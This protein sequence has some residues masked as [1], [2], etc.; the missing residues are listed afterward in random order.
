VSDIEKLRENA[1]WR[2]VNDEWEDIL[3]ELESTLVVE[4]YP[5]VYRT[6]GRVSALMSVLE[7]LDRLEEV[8]RG[9]S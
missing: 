7:T 4:D 8:I 9:S 3:T 5:Y 6:Q 2:W 1:A